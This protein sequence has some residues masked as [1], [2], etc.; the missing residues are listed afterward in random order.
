MYSPMLRGTVEPATAD[1]RSDRVSVRYT[2]IES[3]TTDG[4]ECSMD[5]NSA[6]PGKREGLE[7]RFPPVAG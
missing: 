7:R 1:K 2:G 5:T 3:D 4:S 6:Q